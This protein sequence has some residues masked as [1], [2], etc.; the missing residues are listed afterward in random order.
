VDFVLSQ[1][2]AK[3]TLV[4]ESSAI[5]QNDNSSQD[6]T[7]A[8]VPAPQLESTLAVEPSVTSS[9]GGVKKTKAKTSWL[10]SDITWPNPDNPDAGTFPQE[11][12][13][14]QRFKLFP[15]ITEGPWVVTTA[16]RSCPAMLGQKVVQRYFRGDNYFE[17]DVHVGSSII[18]SNI[19]G[20]CRG[21][22]KNFT[23]D[24][25]VILQ[26][27]SEAELPEV[28]LSCLSIHRIDLDTRK[29]L[30]DVV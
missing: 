27:E 9:A 11:D 15:T 16:V 30:Y 25:G 19:V 14:N 10:P 8:S 1:R 13:R 20:V 23:C 7:I 24:I 26:G 18:A 5:I 17:V 4:E 2:K 6:V 21:Y 22:A 28:L 29:K 12:F 3:E